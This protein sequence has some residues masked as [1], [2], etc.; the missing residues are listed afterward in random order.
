M[1]LLELNQALW[2]IFMETKEKFP[3]PHNEIS[4]EE[5]VGR[6]EG[7]VPDSICIQIFQESS[8]DI[9]SNLFRT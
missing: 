1:F 2:E 7:R 8:N 6:R 5:R 3:N 9:L 4:F